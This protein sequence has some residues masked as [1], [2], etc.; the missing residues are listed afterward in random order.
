MAAVLPA[1]CPHA[2][3]P[4]LASQ[5]FSSPVPPAKVST[6]EDFICMTKG[7]TLATAKA[8]SAGNSCQQEEVIAT[9]NLSHCAITDMLRACNVQQGVSRGCGSSMGLWGAV[10]TL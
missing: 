8:V 2:S 5:V 7:I 9:A 6:P 3:P 1:G 10:C 4:P